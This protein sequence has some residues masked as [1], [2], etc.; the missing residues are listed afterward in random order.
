M[1][2]ST[3]TPLV[4][5]TDSLFKK[6]VSTDV[7]KKVCLGFPC[8]KM[9]WSLLQVNTHTR[10]EVSFPVGIL[11]QFVESFLQVYRNTAKRVLRNLV[12]TIGHEIVIVD[13]WRKG[14]GQQKTT[15]WLPGYSRRDRARKVKSKRFKSG[16]IILYR[17]RLL[18]R[19]SF[20]QNCVAALTTASE[21]VALL[22][23]IHNIHYCQQLL[24]TFDKTTG[25]AI[26]YE[27]NQTCVSYLI[28]E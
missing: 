18:R 22:E 10:P 15:S 25:S 23:C 20:K 7:G 21:Y 8:R 14:I 9:V 27:K 12:W 28:E 16:H 11:S 19:Q 5:N 4:D 24:K 1:A 26:I 13:I 6:A 17:G 3:P 2:K